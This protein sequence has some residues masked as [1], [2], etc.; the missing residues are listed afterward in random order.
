MSGD[1]METI[2]NYTS[3][4]Y[5]PTPSLIFLVLY[6]IHLGLYRLFFHPLTRFHWPKLAATSYW[7]EYYYDVSLQGRYLR[8]IKELHQIYG[9]RMLSFMNVFEKEHRA[10]GF[11]I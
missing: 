10:D 11:S 1:T 2:L 5:L 8:K 3:R 4:A 9:K 7:F 6:Y